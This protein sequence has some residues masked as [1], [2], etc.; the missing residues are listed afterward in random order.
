[1]QPC[2][3]LETPASS[4]VQWE[5]LQPAPA[6]SLQDCNQWLETGTSAQALCQGSAS[7]HWSPAYMVQQVSPCLSALHAII[8][9]WWAVSLHAPHVHDVPTAKS[10]C[11]RCIPCGKQ[12]G[13]LA[14]GWQPWHEM[15]DLTQEQLGLYTHQY[16]QA[17]WGQVA[18]Q[19]AAHVFVF[20]CCL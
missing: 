17:C 1:M 8:L 5:E 6:G 16:S 10:I 11:I 7:R 15:L 4:V 9:L 3:V 14:A 13:C 2:Q 20:A 19:L 12:R 18:D